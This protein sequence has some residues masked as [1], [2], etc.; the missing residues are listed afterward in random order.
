MVRNIN[1]KMGQKSV[2]TRKTKNLYDFLINL[3]FTKNARRGI[4][5]S[6]YLFIYCLEF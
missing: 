3:F 6:V 1:K 5:F 4:H 2:K